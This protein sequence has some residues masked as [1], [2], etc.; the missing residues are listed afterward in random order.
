MKSSIELKELRNDIISKL[1]VIKETA[2]AEERDLT[3]DENNDMDTLLKNADEYSVKIE[4]AEKV[5]TEIRKNVKVSGTPVQKI[6]TDK[7]LRGWSLLK[8]LTKLEMEDN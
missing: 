7:E 2:T 6:N 8:Q 5:E 3:T 1:E 4:R